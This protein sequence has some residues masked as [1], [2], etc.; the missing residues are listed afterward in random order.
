VT[1]VTNVELEH[2]DV[3]GKTRRAIAEEKVGILKPGAVLVT[4]LGPLDDAGCVLQRAAGRMGCRVR[5]PDAS[6]QG[7]LEQINVAL[8]GMV[9]DHLGSVESTKRLDAWLLS[10]QTIRTARLPGRI[11]RFWYGLH[12]PGGLSAS[13]LPVVLDGAHVPFNL[14]AV[15]D[16]LK[17]EQVIGS[18]PRR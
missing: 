17:R 6:L 11:E 9:L 12:V 16:D 13:P 2:V 4:T 5:R 3:L 18:L 14:Q 8:A 1:I 10:E 15:L 7:T